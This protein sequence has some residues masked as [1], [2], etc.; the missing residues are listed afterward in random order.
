MRIMLLGANGRTGREVIKRALQADD[1]VTALVRDKA[2][3][4]DVSDERLTVYSGDV[5]DPATLA[6]LLGGHDVVISAL[7]PRSPGKESCTIYSKSA[8]SIVS[9]MEQSDIKRLL[10]TST[11]LLF[12]SHK[13]M[14]RVLRF[15]ARNNI[16]EAG[17]MENQICAS[18]LNWTFARVG[19]LNAKVTT[20]YRV[21]EGKF[22]DGGGSISRAALANFLHAE[23]T[24]PK[25]ECKIVGLSG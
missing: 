25:N 13:L 22:P 11:G 5:C 6:P 23:A 14:D 18:N 9:A 17:L 2:S 21:A 7:G 12:P 4:S 24:A 19:F 10:V 20:D 16:R 3:L 8:G 1:T 15:I